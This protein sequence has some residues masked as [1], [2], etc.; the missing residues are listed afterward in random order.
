MPSR[1]NWKFAEDRLARFFGTTRR[2]LSGGNSK[3]GRDDS[4]HPRLFLESKHSKSH[5]VWTLYR[6]TREMARKEKRVPVIGLQEHGK[7]GILL[8]IHTDD[9]D[10][11]LAERT[12]SKQKWKPPKPVRRS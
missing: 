5:A 8:V 11:V 1:P 3:T 4:M 6:K 12:K 10:K 2:P 9:L 7:P